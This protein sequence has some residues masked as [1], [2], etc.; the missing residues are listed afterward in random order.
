MGQE[1]RTK[2]V[3]NSQNFQFE[4]MRGRSILGYLGLDEM[5]E[6]I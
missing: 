4:T 1:K 5:L 3:K 2:E 6:T